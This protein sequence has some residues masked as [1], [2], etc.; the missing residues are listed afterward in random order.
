MTNDL[1]TA[2]ASL[3][4]DMYGGYADYL[5]HIEH[6]AKNNFDVNL[7]AI[8]P[9]NAPYF[10]EPY[11]S[12]PYT[13]PQLRDTVRA[14]MHKFAADGVTSKIILPEDLIFEDRMGWYAKAIMSDPETK[15]FNGAFGGHG[16]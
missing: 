15:N 16:L 1:R 7:T 6:I 5:S 2:D 14:I 8:S 13:D 9:Q 4:S 12:T 3:H 11:E 10:V